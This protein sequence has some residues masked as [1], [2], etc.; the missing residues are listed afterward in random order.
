M[1]PALQALVLVGR[2]PGFE[3]AGRTGREIAIVIDIV[4]AVR[5]HLSSGQM[6]AGRTGVAVI[7]DVVDEVGHGE[8]AALGVAG[9]LC[10]GNAGQNSAAFAGQH[11]V[12]VVI[13][14]VGQHGD[15]LASG[16]IQRLL[17]HRGQ[18][19]PVG[20]D[21]GDLVRD[22]QMVLGI[23]GHLDIVADDAGALAAGRHRPGVGIGQGDLVVGRCFDLPSHLLEGLHLPPQAL[24]LLLEPNRLGLGDIIVLPVRGRAP[25]DS[26]RCWPPPARCAWRPGCA[27]R[28]IGGSRHC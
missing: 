26:A 4:P 19:R 24:D 13:A 9:C 3:R 12:A 27:D 11:L 6:L 18:L 17:P 28:R 7:P 23:D 16:R 1:F 2:A 22:D 20:A 25:P 8:E 5:T 15:L 14:A 10:L 21:V